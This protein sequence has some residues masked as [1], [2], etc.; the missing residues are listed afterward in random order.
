MAQQ[1]TSDCT[2]ISCLR[3]CCIVLSGRKSRN[4]LGHS[5]LLDWQ[6]R[7]KQGPT[8]YEAQWR[9]A[10]QSTSSLPSLPTLQCHVLAE[11]HYLLKGDYSHLARHRA[12]AVSMCHQLGLHQNQK[13][14]SITVLES[15]TRKKTFWSQYVLDKYDLQF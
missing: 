6:S 4:F 5:Y 11:L 10:I 8:S 14:L 3:Y 1:K 9:K 7:I 15:E 12:I 2:T 13:Y